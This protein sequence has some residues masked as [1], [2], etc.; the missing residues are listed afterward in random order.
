MQQRQQMRAFEDFR[1]SHEISHLAS[2]NQHLS[3]EQMDPYAPTIVQ[4]LLS[5]GNEWR[6]I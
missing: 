5:G 3:Q 4:D 2:T 1:G 6:N